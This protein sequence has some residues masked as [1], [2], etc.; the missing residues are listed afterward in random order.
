MKT[1]TTIVLFI[2][3]C[4]QLAAQTITGNLS[5]LVN[6][7]IKLE[8]FSGLAT[9]PIA[10][11]TIDEKGNFLLTYTKNDI[12]MGY[13]TSIDNKPL[14]VILSG[15][16]IALQGE[17]LSY[18]ETIKI[19]KG[20]E[21]RAFETY[22]KEHPKREQAMSA[23][24]YLEKMYANDALF[25]EQNA[26]KSAIISEKQR[27]KKQDAAFLSNLPKNSYVSWFL[28]TRKLVSSVSAVAQYRTEEIPA[29]FAAFRNLD[30][31][32]QHLYK[33]GLFRDAI[34][35]HFWLLENSGRSLDSVFIEM[36]ISID[37]MMKH[38]VK[39]NKKLNEVTHHLFDLLEKRSLFQASEYLAVKVLNDDSC[40]L[41]ANLA[42]Q[43]ETYRAMKKGSIAPEIVFDKA[44]FAK[45]EQ[46]IATLSDLESKYT[47]VAFGASWCPKCT[48]EFPEMA[49]FYKQWK[50]QGVE[51]VFI[52]LEEDRKSFTDFTANFPFPSYSD[53]KKWDS[54]IAT[55]YY[56]FATPTMFLLN[57]KREIVLRPI[58]V[59]QVD[60][61][62]RSF[63]TDAK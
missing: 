56:V 26:P 25:S 42:K 2:F 47:L 45:P 52:A 13:L 53:L 33:S 28:P 29:T 22:A 37:A 46:A 19:T 32:D 60:A 10:T 16:D 5:Q 59:K 51:V 55:D 7:E 27:I 21:N 38:L 8:G 9:Y 15:E 11:T 44:S 23:W 58:S 31:S 6:Q 34:D 62:I 4:G 30:Y 24:L 63:V 17:A 50:A 35:S 36:K 20:T 40:V 14:F 18:V 12:G 54:K 61:W 3:L 48:E 39:D 43:L 41:E 1:G 57:N 49:T